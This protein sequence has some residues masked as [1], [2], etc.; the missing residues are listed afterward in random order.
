MVLT[1]LERLESRKRA[2]AKW[3][4]KP[5]NKEARYRRA[6]APEK[7]EARLAVA[8][9][10][11]RSNLDKSRKYSASWRSRN[12]KSVRER[13]AIR[14]AA[15]KLRFKVYR[16]S[17]LLRGMLFDLTYTQFMSFWKSPCSYCGD[18][19][20]TVGLDRVNNADGYTITNVAPCCRTCNLMKSSKTRDEFIAHCR[21][22][23]EAA[24]VK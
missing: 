12:K 20:P 5:G 14:R 13:S 23:A 18:G 15:P 9:E 10:W 11:R 3:Y 17:A 4:S 16:D 1:S 8:A 2:S 24:D 6:M 22:I 7:R 21:K 19:I